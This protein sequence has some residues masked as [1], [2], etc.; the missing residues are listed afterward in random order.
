[1]AEQG[2]AVNAGSKIGAADWVAMIK[3]SEQVPEFLQK[4]I[5]AK[6]DLIV[7]WSE[8]R[9]P[10]NTIPRDWLADLATAFASG[11]WEITTAIETFE[12]TQ[13][14]SGFRVR[15]RI[16]PDLR[17][18]DFGP[19]YWFQTGPNQRE[20]SPDNYSFDKTYELGNM[21]FEF[22]ETFSSERVN[23]QAREGDRSAETRLQSKRALIIVVNR[24]VVV[25]AKPAS[26]GSLAPQG[27]LA[28]VAGPLEFDLPEPTLIYALLHEL[29]A[30]AGRMNQGKTSLHRDEKVE[31]IVAEIE[32]MFPKDVESAHTQRVS[33]ALEEV[34]QRLKEQQTSVSPAA[35]GRTPG[36]VHGSSSGVRPPGPL[37]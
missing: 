20:W 30:H 25:G 3:R 33:K 24:A 16:S 8:I 37:R 31:S 11:E 17:K 2:I 14:S 26:P 34:A 19:G 5:K 10:S 18:G 15:R 35:K 7:G 23:K 4:G 1:M 13:D 22:G 27:S 6:G 9:Q 32:E 29:A 21:A 28:S 12:V 36:P